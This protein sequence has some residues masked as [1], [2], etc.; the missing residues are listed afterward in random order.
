MSWGYVGAAVV[1]G[2]MASDASDDASDAADARAASASDSSADLLAFEQEKYDDWKDIYGDVEQNLADFYENM[3]PEF[4][5]SAGLEEEAKSFATAQTN[6]KTS[7]AQ[8][9]LGG[10]GLEAD[11]IAGQEIQSAEKRAEIRRDAPLQ[12]AEMQQNFLQPNLAAKQS[13]ERA[14]SSAMSSGASIQDSILSD[15]QAAAEADANS[16][17]SSTGT[18]LSTGLESFASDSS[19]D[20]K[21]V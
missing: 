3:T 1:T 11:L 16:L 7:L 14:I 12:V 17:W 15:S 13:G 18:L 21:E 6:I 5:T 9:N 10:S 20:I 8:R 2:V 4:L 19:D